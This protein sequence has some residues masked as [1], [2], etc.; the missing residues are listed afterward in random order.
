MSR[1]TP[2]RNRGKFAKTPTLEQLG[3][4]I[5][6]GSLENTISFS[7]FQT[8]GDWAWIPDVSWN[9]Q[10]DSF[11]YAALKNENELSGNPESNYFEIKFYDIESQTKLTV[12]QS[13]G[14]FGSPDVSPGYFKVGTILGNIPKNNIIWIY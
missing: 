8:T 11:F 10:S 2:Y 1:R 6:D 12:I 14:I 13:V 3:Y 9:T 7:P 4:D 5:S